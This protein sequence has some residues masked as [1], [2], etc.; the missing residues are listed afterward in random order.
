MTDTDKRTLDALMATEVMGW[1]YGLVT[2]DADRWERE[3]ISFFSVHDW[4]PTENLNQ[5]FMVVEK[6]TKS[7]WTLRLC[8]PEMV[9]AWTAEFVPWAGYEGRKV[10]AATPALAICLAAEEAMK[11][12]SHDPNA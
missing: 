3:G 4:H 5:A 12:A 11:G 6:M 10:S 9:D 7:Q 8:S 2:A 1:R